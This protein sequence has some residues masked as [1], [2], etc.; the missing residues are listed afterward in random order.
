VVVNKLVQIIESSGIKISSVVDDEIRCLCPFHTDTRAS[1]SINATKEKWICFKGC[2]KGN[3]KQFFDRL[4]VNI[5]TFYDDSTP[6]LKIETVDKS[7]EYKSFIPS[8]AKKCSELYGHFTR[9]NILP[10]VVDKFGLLYSPSDRA[11]I[12]PV[13]DVTGVCRGCVSIYDAGWKIN[14]TSREYLFGANVGT[15]VYDN[16]I[17][18]VEGVHDCLSIWQSGYRSGALL[19]CSISRNQIYQALAISQDVIL[20]LDFDSAGRKGSV[21][22]AKTLYK[23]GVDPKIVAIARGGKLDGKDPNDLTTDQISDLI[24]G[25][26]KF[27]SVVDIL[28]SDMLE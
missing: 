28:L 2:G 23:L 6:E 17:V 5:D 20:F 7:T 9:R 21:K 27:S 13:I 22:I 14:H 8:D 26:I 18:L 11:V 24:Q 15:G 3:L 1:M 10:E 16:N 25:A 4:G 12:A 19:G